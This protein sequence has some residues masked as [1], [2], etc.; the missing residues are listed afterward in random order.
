MKVSIVQF[1]GTNC[2]YD[3]QHAFVKLGATT[4]VVWHKSETIP[5][6]TDLL[7]VPAAET[8]QAQRDVP[9]VA[10]IPDAN[11]QQ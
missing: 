11:G 6:D 7:V 2:E 8:R 10:Q 5:A 9:V 1:P 3:T 4:E